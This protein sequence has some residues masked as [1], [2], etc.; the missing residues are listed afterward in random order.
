L[1]ESIKFANYDD[2]SSLKKSDI[3]DFIKQPIRFGNDSFIN[4][5]EMENKKGERCYI[6]TCE[7]YDYAKKRGFYFPKSSDANMG[8]CL[9]YQCGLLKAIKEASP[10]TT[11]FIDKPRI[12][13]DPR[14]IPI[15][16]FPFYSHDNKSTYD[17]K[18]SENLI[19]ITGAGFNFIRIENQ[20]DGIGQHLTEVA[21]ADFNG[22][23][24]E[25]ILL[26]KYC[27]AIG[28]TL[29]FGNI[30]VLTRK[31]NDQPF[32]IITDEILHKIGWL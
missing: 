14:L 5:V 19:K 6:C 10:P 4:D 27:W 30:Q 17:D 11:S 25:D 1:L 24:I 23:G 32:E 22:D 29:R 16:L 28:G 21:R 20:K 13:L 26:F 18:L 2:I 9:E 3:N 7:E 8:I 15:S 12:G 31:S